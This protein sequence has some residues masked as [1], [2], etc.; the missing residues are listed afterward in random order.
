[1]HGPPSRGSATRRTL[2][3]EPRP[4]S[5][6][7]LAARGQRDHVHA[8]GLRTYTKR[9]SARAPRVLEHVVGVLESSS[10]SRSSRAPA[11]TRVEG[12]LRRP[13][14]R[15]LPARASCVRDGREA[16][17]RRRARR[18]LALRRPARRRRS[19]DSR[20]MF[21]AHENLCLSLPMTRAGSD[22]P[23]RRACSGGTRSSTSKSA[24]ERSAPDSCLASGCARPCSSS[25]ART[26][27]SRN[28][29]LGGA[30]SSTGRAR[31]CQ[32][33][34]GAEQ[35]AISGRRATRTRPSCSPVAGQRE[36]QQGARFAFHGPMAR[37]QPKVDAARSQREL[38]KALLEAELLER[39]QQE[40]VIADRDPPVPTSRSACSI[41]PR[42]P[43]ARPLGVD[44]EAEVERLAS[45]FADLCGE[46]H[47]VGRDDLP[48]TGRL[49][50]RN[51]LVATAEDRTRA[52]VAR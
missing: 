15:S 17:M 25:L 5:R 43:R 37:E 44:D 51:Q 32:R 19:H 9:S 52:V 29:H 22:S 21:I 38:A 8:R 26:K 13:S 27:C 48:A 39:R 47:R 12:G 24:I 23:P 28:D 49:A 35:R 45:G 4:R 2:G 30:A 1:M 41:A 46:H 31:R 3:N 14:M 36:H 20:C 33:W 50:D 10:S 11:S 7:R 34:R 16:G 42:S 18:R 40:I 6:A